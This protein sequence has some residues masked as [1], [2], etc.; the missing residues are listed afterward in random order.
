MKRSLAFSW[1]PAVALAGLLHAQATKIILVRHGEKVV[2]TD[3]NPDLTDAGRARAAALA[4][5]M[6]SQHV[7]LVLATPYRRTVATATPAAKAAGLPVTEIAVAGGLQAYISGVLNAVARA[8]GPVLIVG[9]SNTIAPLLKALGGPALP[10]L[11]DNEYDAMFVL[12]R[13][14][15]G[16]PVFT[17]K[18][19]GTPDPPG[20][21]AC[22][23]GGIR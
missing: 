5:A 3:P 14:A 6:D 13:S 2:G 19:V 12:D 11:C 18:T 1:I 9:H 23:S 10:D 20:A 8:T 16:P 21:H 17:R 4:A 7:T 15:S 22:H